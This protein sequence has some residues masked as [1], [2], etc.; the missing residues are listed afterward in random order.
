ML[1]PVW[2][3]VVRYV[4]FGYDET[5][6]VLIDFEA[7]IIGRLAARFLASE[8]LRSLVVGQF[9]FE[10][11]TGRLPISEYQHKNED[12]STSDQSRFRR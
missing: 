2:R 3:M 11:R 8:S 12:H 6:M 1:P 9:E 10:A 5:R 4:R 7:A